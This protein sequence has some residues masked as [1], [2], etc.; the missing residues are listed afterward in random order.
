[1]KF[2]IACHLCGWPKEVASDQRKVMQIVR[3][4]GYDGVEGFGAKTADE[5]NRSPGFRLNP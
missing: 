5:L 2:K 4:A 3:D 1:M